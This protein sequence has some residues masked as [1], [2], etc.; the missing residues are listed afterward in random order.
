MVVW[1]SEVWESKAVGGLGDR[2]WRERKR[3]TCNRRCEL[4]RRGRCGGGDG[5]ARTR[6]RHWRVLVCVWDVGG[7]IGSWLVAFLVYDQLGQTRYKSWQ[8]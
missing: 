2:V 5:W 8:F 6:F 1:G 3:W 7:G 4:R